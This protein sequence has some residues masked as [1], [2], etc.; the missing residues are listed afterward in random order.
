M[1]FLTG[2]V[3]PEALEGDYFNYFLKGE[4][5]KLVFI[6]DFVLIGDKLA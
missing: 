4:T 5:G 3:I 1:K 6:G 2:E